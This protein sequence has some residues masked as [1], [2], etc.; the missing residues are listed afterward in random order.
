MNFAENEPKKDLSKRK[1]RTDLFSLPFY[2][3]ATTSYLS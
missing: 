1:H 2:V 3:V